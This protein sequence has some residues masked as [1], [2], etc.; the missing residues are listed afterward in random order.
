MTHR[1]RAGDPPGRRE[2]AGDAGRRPKALAPKNL[3]KPRLPVARAHCRRAN[4][5]AK[6]RADRPRDLY[7]SLSALLGIR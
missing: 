2:A 3:G 7:E 4:G 6:G 1:D 5:R